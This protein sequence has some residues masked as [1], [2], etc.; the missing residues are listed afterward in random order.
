MV[1]HTKKGIVKNHI[2]AGI[3]GVK[4]RQLFDVRVH[5]IVRPSLAIYN[6]LDVPIF[7]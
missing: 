2:T 5:A 4:K 1:N 3:T 7:L 6:F